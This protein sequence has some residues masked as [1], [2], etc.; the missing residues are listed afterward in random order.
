MI[1]ITEVVTSA[2]MRDSLPNIRKKGLEKRERKKEKVSYTIY[3]PGG[4]VGGV[5]GGA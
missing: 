2:L 1:R 5:E 4:V 3:V